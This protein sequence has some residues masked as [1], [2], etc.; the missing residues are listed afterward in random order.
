MGAALRGARPLAHRLGYRVYSDD[1]VELLRRALALRERG[2]SVPAALERAR[3]A[4]GLT[5]RPSI[6]AAIVSGGAAA[7]QLLRK[8]TLMA[9]SR[10]IEDEALARAA[11]P[12][13]FAAFQS[14]RHYRAVQ[15]RY[16]RLAANADAAV[17]FAD[18]PDSRELDGRPAEVPIEPDEALGNEWAV[19]ID[20]PG[21]AACLLAWEHPRSGDVADRERLFESM[22]TLDPQTVRRAAQVSCGLVA[23]SCPDL[24]ARVERLLTDRPM[25]VE[26]P[27]PGLTALTNRLVAYLEASA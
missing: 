6:Y 11:G 19:V 4:G 22:W 17:V 13:V 12:V 15:H 24:A 10:A 14:E 9:I 26:T 21:Y 3:D 25:A 7:P 5:D 27:A 23:R 1:D 20:A 18:F 16:E 8:R 2:L